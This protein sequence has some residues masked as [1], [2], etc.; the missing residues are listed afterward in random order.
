MS[1][2]GAG[3]GGYMPG[4][5]G[6]AGA[7]AAGIAAHNASKGR[8]AQR[9]RAKRIARDIGRARPFV[10]PAPKK[11]PRK[12][13][14]RKR[15]RDQKKSRDPIPKYRKTTTPKGMVRRGMSKRV[16][17]TQRKRKQRL[18]REIAYLNA[19]PKRFVN[20][21][22]VAIEGGFND[23]TY[24]P[25][26]AGV[27][28][29]V[30]LSKEQ[31]MALYDFSIGAAGTFEDAATKL[32][33]DWIQMKYKILNPGNQNIIVDY[34]EVTPRRDKD[35]S[36]LTDISS[37]ISDTTENP[38]TVAGVSE[39]VSASTDVEF[40]PNDYEKFRMNWKVK[41][42]RRVYLG[43]D[44]EAIFSVRR[45]G[46]TI[47]GNTF[48]EDI[49]YKRGL[50]VFSFVRIQGT[51]SSV[52][53]TSEAADYIGYS[54]PALSIICEIRGQCRKLQTAQSSEIARLTLSTANDLNLDATHPGSL[55]TT[56]NDAA[57]IA[58]EAVQA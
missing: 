11:A 15:K 58:S 18:A 3:G 24:H 25:M 14:T 54:K 38:A 8:L 44:D 17:F 30:F 31:C 21:H 49:T 37:S 40:F 32:H 39:Q 55:Y 51:I 22:T 6:I 2:F 7:I 48:T 47:Y 52:Y 56:I 4:L 46:V 33:L 20:T 34:Y 27:A 41:R 13:K 36:P 26:C 9:K 53:D 35:E 16:L 43:A 5:G 45:K 10:P 12:R 57:V 42:R 23:A 1:K 29:R 28:D 19:P 50:S